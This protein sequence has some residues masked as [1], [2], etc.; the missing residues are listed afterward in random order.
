MCICQLHSW[1]ACD[2]CSETIADRK[3][4]YSLPSTQGRDIVSEIEQKRKVTERQQNLSRCTG[5]NSCDC[6]RCR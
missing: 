5:T 3:G 1:Q 2:D 6:K 4:L